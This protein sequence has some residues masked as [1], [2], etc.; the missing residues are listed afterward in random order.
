MASLTALTYILLN[1][2]NWKANYCL[3]RYINSNA[4]VFKGVRIIDVLFTTFVEIRVTAS[5]LERRINDFQME[6]YL[7]QS[8]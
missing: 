1:K 3:M 4:D 2:L 5:K 8:I 6:D 7:Y